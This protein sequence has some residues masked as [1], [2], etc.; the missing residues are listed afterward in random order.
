MSA[1]ARVAAKEVKR[2]APVATPASVRAGAIKGRLKKAIYWKAGNSTPDGSV[3][4]VSIYPGKLG[5]GKGDL[6]GAYYR[7]PVVR[8]TSGSKDPFRIARST[9]AMTQ[10]GGRR[11]SP[12]KQAVKA[13]G[14]NARVSVKPIQARPFVDQGVQATTG[15]QE[16][17]WSEVYNRYMTDDAFSRTMNRPSRRTW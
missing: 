1:V 5:S 7:Y 13:Q 10:F 12:W 9:I 11:A 6:T 15:A 2:R 16:R 14:L 17:A 3:S 4:L 8:G